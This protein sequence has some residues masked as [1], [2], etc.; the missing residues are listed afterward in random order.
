[1]TKINDTTTTTPVRETRYPTYFHRGSERG[2][3]AEVL[4]IETAMS[5]IRAFADEHG[6][7]ADMDTFAPLDEAQMAAFIASLNVEY[8]ANEQVEDWAGFDAVLRR[9]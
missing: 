9:A 3:E 4:L 8:E 1:M 2:H 5:S 7:L 6:W